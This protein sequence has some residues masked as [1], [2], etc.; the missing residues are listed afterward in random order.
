MSSMPWVADA[1]TDYLSRVAA[2]P[3]A[4]YATLG[5][6][7]HIS[8]QALQQGGV[9][10]QVFALFVDAASPCHPTVQCLKQLHAFQRMLSVWGPACLQP[11]ELDTLAHPFCVPLRAVLSIEGGEA[12]DGS[13]ELLH[14]FASLGVRA[15]APVWNHR[16]AL[17]Y[18]AVDKATKQKG[19]TP[20]GKRM[21]D[22]MNR[23]AVAVDVSHLN[24]AGFWD[25]IERS[26]APVFASHSNAYA[27]CPHPRNLDD[28]QIKALIRAKGFLGLNFSARF[29]SLDG[30][31]TLEP[32]VRHALHILDL[33]GEDVLGFGS[34]LDGVARLP[35]GVRG[36]QD[37]P[38]V[39]QALAQAGLS[40]AVLD[41]IAHQNLVRYL[42]QFF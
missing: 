1:H 15:M 34:D 10:L 14:V 2:D 32:L 9:G 19:L 28:A 24:G 27:L 39:L 40:R 25:C 41:K 42:S 18:P 29:L 35:D 23:H 38:M 33:G 37:L 16:N 36:A 7:R 26:S 11:A 17:G 22:A 5:T 8:L 31:C 21:V 12:C 20:C 4:L 3:H 13:T 30:R 6:Q